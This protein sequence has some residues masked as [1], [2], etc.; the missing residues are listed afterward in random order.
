MLKT[1]AAVC[2]FLCL[3][4]IAAG[5]LL[6][7]RMKLERFPFDMRPPLQGGAYRIYNDFNG[8]ENG[9]IYIPYRPREYVRIIHSVSG[10]KPE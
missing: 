5:A 4:L 7:H 10:D 9:F 6:H 3:S 1:K 2:A 8:R